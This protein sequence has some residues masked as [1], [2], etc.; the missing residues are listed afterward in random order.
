M[1]EMEVR[2]RR[3]VGAET[4]K[5]IEIKSND[6]IAPTITKS[7]DAIGPTIV[8]GRER[9]YR[10]LEHSIMVQA[11]IRSRYASTLVSSTVENTEAVAREV[12][13]SVFLPETAF[14]SRFAME[15][16]GI[17]YV[18]EVREKEE[19]WRK[20]KDAVEEGK[21]AGHVGVTARHSNRF[22]VS[23]NTSPHSIVTFYL[24]YEELL[25]RRG[26]VYE[27]TVNIS[28]HQRLASF[29]LG[30]S[31]T[32]QR[33]FT[34]LEVPGLR[35]HM[36]QGA[37]NGEDK[38]QGASI[39]LS[40]THPG[41]ATI[42]YSPEPSWLEQQLKEGNQ[43]LQFILQYEVDRSREGGEVQLMDGYF[44][45]F[46]APENLP[47]MPKHVIFVLDTSGSMRN[48]KMQ[49]T[50]E[51]MVKILGEMRQRDFITIIDFATNVTVW[52]RVEGE[53][54]IP[55]SLEN[56]EAATRHVEQLE[57]E[58]ETNINGAL[59]QALEI[60]SQTQEKK[61]LE[62][63]QPMVLF[64]TDGHPTVGETDTL[65]ILQN[66]KKANADTK[67]AV[68]SLAFGRKTDFSMLRLLS[69]QN[70]GFARKIYTAADASL[71]LEGFYQEVSSPILSNVTFDYL[72]SNLVEDSLTETA[73]HTFYQGG[74]MVVAGMM[75]L[76][77]GAEQPTIEY[78]VTA[79]QATGDY[80]LGGVGGAEV[81]PVLSETV[82]TYID[83]LPMH[84]ATKHLAG[85]T[86]FMER[87]WA[88][89]TIK[90]LL[91]RVEKGQ[92]MSCNPR[93]RD[94]REEKEENREEDEY[95]EEEEEMR[96]PVICNNLERAL[97]LSLRYQFVTP[98]TSL[99]VIKPD[100]IEKGDIAEADLFNRKIQ[101]YSSGLSPTSSPILQA[102]LLLLLL[103]LPCLTH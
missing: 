103:L 64:L 44:V 82:D 43:P 63:V 29:N 80:S 8:K 22:R 66:V 19:A 57:A 83:M 97:F 49:Q 42:T 46:V 51:A 25:G 3:E 40:P 61:V 6:A 71:Q 15:I 30:V 17:F 88:Y 27:Y 65:R 89:L 48:R 26:G 81:P 34:R 87:L 70:F 1:E 59:L 85:N 32:E 92:L 41:Q 86:N 100:T 2:K 36:E 95:E 75:D 72:H 67:T 90:N 38:L 77:Q 9:K 91:T 7:N 39:I 84:S 14:I 69:V 10:R 47:P 18:A 23:V 24:L 20:Y 94:R 58:G 73:F 99:V 93:I 101:L 45:H 33:N 12:F 102:A 52:E 74:E 37:G 54:I 53:A 78:K 76:S 62:G 98:L 13:F 31:V 55:A 56:I 50:I 28:P 16:E 21:T 5:R 96:V 60:V 79:H 11:D 4:G 35:R 68:F